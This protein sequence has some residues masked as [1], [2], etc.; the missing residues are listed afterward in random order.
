M[1]LADIDRLKESGC[2]FIIA[3]I[4]AGTEYQRHPNEFQVAVTRELFDAGVDVVTG[5]HPHVI[6]P[7]E[8]QTRKPG[9][10]EKR[11]LAAY[12]LGN[13]ISNQRWRY[14]DCGLILNLDIVKKEDGTPVLEGASYIP[15]WVDTFEE[16]GLTRYRVLPVS[17]ALKDYQEGADPLLTEQDYLALE[18][19]WQD[20]TG[21]IS[22]DFSPGP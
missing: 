6:E 8:W 10:V 21:F 22:P 15:V 14:S 20:T 18:Q 9:G 13:F 2:Q 12:S 1:M 7:L 17:P 19:V 11:V 16:E 4:H 3:I 5:S